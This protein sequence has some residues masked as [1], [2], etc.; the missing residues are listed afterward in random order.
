[1]LQQVAND[2]QALCSGASLALTSNGI[3]PAFKSL[4][5]SQIDIASSDVTARPAWNFTDHPIVALL[6]A[7]IVSP[8]VQISDLSSASLQDI[9]QGKITN[10]SRVGGP[11]EPITVVLR[12]EGDPVNA[13][14]RVFVL[15]GQAIHARVKRLQGSSSDVVIQAVNQTAGAVSFVPLMAALGAN[16]QVLSID[17]VAPGVDALMLGLYPFWSVG[18]LYTQGD[19]TAQALAYVRFLNTAQEA[20]GLKQLGAVPVIMLQQS[21]LASHLPGPEI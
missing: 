11:N 13:I 10:W 9:Y 20:G 4:Q 19:G 1:M 16:A 12:P 17:G 6:Y 15:K 8:D 18:H 3:R 14:F 5:Q 7:V 2:Y 21:V